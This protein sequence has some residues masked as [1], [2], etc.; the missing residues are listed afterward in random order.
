M[1]G[2]IVR[3]PAVATAAHR[4]PVA[5]P[6]T[7]LSPGCRGQ[8]SRV[9]A[10]R[11][12]GGVGRRNPAASSISRRSTPRWHQRNE[13]PR[14]LQSCIICQGGAWRLQPCCTH[15]RTP[16]REPHFLSGSR[17]SVRSQPE[18]DRA[19]AAAGPA[20]DRSQTPRARP[21]LRGDEPANGVGPPRGV[22]SS[23]PPNPPA[24][25]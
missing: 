8:L 20:A 14:G 1:V 11:H 22:P 12:T 19:H 10:T 21:A 2:C 15:C 4:R 13:R 24:L 3:R 25:I 5:A 23:Y 16:V 9:G 6:G 17:F 7:M 18:S